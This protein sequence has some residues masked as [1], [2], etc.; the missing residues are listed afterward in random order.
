M[1]DEATAAGRGALAF[2]G[3]RVPF[4]AGQSIGAALMAHGISS[5]R[6]TRREAAPRGLFCGIGVCFDCLV[7]VDGERDQRACL[8]PAR[9][10]QDVR[11]GDPAEPLPN[12]GSS[13]D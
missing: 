6:T 12:A 3:E 11:T 2:D 8:V 13:D 9:E 10:D 4:R 7:T 1:T 5:W